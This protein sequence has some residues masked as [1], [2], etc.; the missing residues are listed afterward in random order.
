MKL[1]NN[2]SGVA[3]IA[4]ILVVVVIAAIGIVGWKVW[5]ST[6]ED[7][8]SSADTTTKTTTETNQNSTPNTTST[9]LEVKELGVKLKLTSDTKDLTYSVNKDGVAVLSSTS[10]AKEEPKCAADYVDNSQYAIHGV[11]S[12]SYFTDPNGTETGPGPSNKQNYPD[13]ILLNGKYYYILTNQSFCV[14]VGTKN[15][16]TDKAYQIETSLVHALRNDITLEKL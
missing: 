7:K 10:L 8:S 9:Y 12:V 5:D 3:H 4:A 6:K 13:S 14:N 11:G 1:K 15:N 2:Q 16:P